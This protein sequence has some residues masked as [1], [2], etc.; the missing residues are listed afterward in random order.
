MRKYLVPNPSELTRWQGKMFGSRFWSKIILIWMGSRKSLCFWY[1]IFFNW[2]FW[3]FIGIHPY[4]FSRITCASPEWTGKEVWFKFLVKNNSDMDV[5]WEI[6]L[7]WVLHFFKSIFVCIY[8]DQP[9]H[10]FQ[11]DK[12]QPRVE[13]ERFLAQVFG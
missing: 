1:Y 11:N 13:S 2:N 8:R 10:I 7:F 12:Y 5:K 3:K 6:T 9:I 4:T